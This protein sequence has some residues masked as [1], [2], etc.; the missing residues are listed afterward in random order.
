MEA[1]L[2]N[3]QNRTFTMRGTCPHC[4]R[5]SAFLLATSVHVDTVGGS[6]LRMVAGLQC[7]ACMD[8]I[9][10]AALYG[11]NSGRFTYEKHY[12]L[13]RPPQDVD[14]TVPPDVS[15]DFKEAL[16]CEWVKSYRACV[17]MCRRAI[18]SSVI[19]LGAKGGRLIDQIDDLFKN[20]KITEALKEFAHE[21]RLT[22][23]DGAHPDRD[24]LT[25]VKEKDSSAIFAFTREYLHHVYVMPAKLKAPKTPVAPEA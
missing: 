16:R 4:A 18:Q 25:E 20:G 12:P 3:L 14:P 8:F 22:G 24:G 19:A 9:L 2:I 11:Q 7:Q 15:E 23:N 10:A 21:V 1:V 17:V 6:Q 13:G 5:A